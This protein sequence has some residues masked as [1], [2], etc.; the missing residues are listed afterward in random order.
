MT[1][2]LLMPHVHTPTAFDTPFLIQSVLQR[3][4]L[5]TEGTEQHTFGVVVERGLGRDRGG[6]GGA[7]GSGAAHLAARS[8]QPAD[9]YPR[10]TNSHF[11]R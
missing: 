6:S 11:K 1:N 4:A 8:L 2:H 10:K 9:P 5:N 7:R 3:P